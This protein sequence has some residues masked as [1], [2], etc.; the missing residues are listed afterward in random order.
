VFLDELA[1]RISHP[2]VVKIDVEGHEEHVLASLFASN[3]ADK[4]TDIIIECIEEHH[5]QVLDQML[6][7]LTQLAFT[8]PLAPTVLPIMTAISSGNPAP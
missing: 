7:S 1:A 2:V 5:P 8:S 6:A 4:V 3:L